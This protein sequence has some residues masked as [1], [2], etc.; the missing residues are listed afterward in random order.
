M[1]EVCLSV[2]PIQPVAVDFVL[3]LI[4]TLPAMDNAEL[5]RRYE[6]S[7]RGRRVDVLPVNSAHSIPV[8]A[9]ILRTLG[10]RISMLHIPN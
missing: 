2:S 1:L 4:W 6:E 9:L 8:G 10:F 5:I 3:G 7:Q